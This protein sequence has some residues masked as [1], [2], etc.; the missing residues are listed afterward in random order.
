MPGTR[1]TRATLRRVLN[2]L[3]SLTLAILI[4]AIVLRPDPPTRP[5][6]NMLRLEPL[7]QDQWEQV[8]A[9]GHRIGPDNAYPSA[10]SMFH[11]WLRLVI[12]PDDVSNNIQGGSHAGRKG[13]CGSGGSGATTVA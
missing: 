2:L 6:R 13:C 9:S 11:R 1:N 7:P 8:R 4:G 3:L 12:L 10:E 5:S